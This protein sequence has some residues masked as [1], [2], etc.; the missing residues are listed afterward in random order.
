ME[1]ILRRSARAIK[2]RD[3]YKQTRIENLEYSAKQLAAKALRERRQKLQE[4]ARYAP[5]A[6]RKAFWLG[7]STPYQGLGYKTPPKSM[8]HTYTDFPDNIRENPDYKWDLGDVKIIPGYFRKGD[9]VVVISGPDKGLI[10]TIDAADNDKQ[11]VLLLRLNRMYVSYSAEVQKL[12]KEKVGEMYDM[13]LPVQYKDIRLVHRLGNRDVIVGKMLV[14]KCD[15][16]E[17]GVAYQRFI[18][19]TY[20]DLDAAN[21][22][23]YAKKRLDEDSQRRKP[24]MLPSDTWLTQANEVSWSPSLDHLPM[25]ESVVDEIITP[26]SRLNP[27]IDDALVEKTMAKE[28]I[29]E[30][31][32]RAVKVMVSSPAKEVYNRRLEAARLAR[33]EAGPSEEVLSILGQAMAKNFKATGRQPVPIESRRSSG[34]RRE[35]DK[36]TVPIKIRSSN[37]ESSGKPSLRSKAPLPKYKWPTVPKKSIRARRLAQNS[38]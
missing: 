9:R 15:D 4:Y 31:K 27:N 16:G 32:Q 33:E 36:A 21:P 24:E 12:Y 2:K 10:D 14:R 37:R 7:G 20:E 13:Q 25:P 30:L 11:T 5:D 29:K 1:S 22:I 26:F 35:S 3:V 8:S 38:E 19:G 23:D 17:G 34:K 6:E 18:P 28:A